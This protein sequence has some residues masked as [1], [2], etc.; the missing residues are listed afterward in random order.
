[1]P[2]A[3]DRVIVYQADRLHVGINDRAAHEVQSPLLQIFGEGIA[4]LSLH[5]HVRAALAL[6][7]DRPVPNETPNVGV[8]GSEFL[9]NREKRA[10]VFHRTVNLET[11]AHQS[12]IEQQFFDAC[13]SETSHSR[14]I[15]SGERPPVVLAFAQDRLPT[16]PRLR[17]LEN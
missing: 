12:G 13:L 1:M 17:A 15:E 5:G 4:F 3:V 14:G 2:E 7:V 9:L 16:E 11:V 8:E 10:R 6:T